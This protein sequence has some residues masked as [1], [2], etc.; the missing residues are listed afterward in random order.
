MAPPSQRKRA[1][2]GL[3]LAERQRH[4]QQ[5]L[6]ATNYPND[7]RAYTNSALQGGRGDLIKVDKY[8]R[9]V[10]RLDDSMT[11]EQKKS[12]GQDKDIYAVAKWNTKKGKWE[13]ETYR[14]PDRPQTEAFMISEGTWNTRTDA[15]MSM[16]P[17]SEGRNAKPN[18]VLRPGKADFQPALNINSVRGGRDYRLSIDDNREGYGKTAKFAPMTFNGIG[19]NAPLDF[20]GMPINPNNPINGIGGQGKYYTDIAGEHTVPNDETYNNNAMADA[21]V[22]GAKPYTAAEKAKT[23]FVGVFRTATDPIGSVIDLYNGN[24]LEHNVEYTG[25]E[26]GIGAALTVGCIVGMEIVQ[27]GRG[28]ARAIQ[29]GTTA[30]EVELG[31]GVVADATESAAATSSRPLAGFSAEAGA[32]R[33]AGAGAGAGATSAEGN[34]FLEPVNPSGIAG[35]DLELMKFGKT[36]N[37]L[38][39][40]DK[41]ATVM[42]S[43]ENNSFFDA[44]RT[45]SPRDLELEGMP[46]LHDKAT[47]VQVWKRMGGTF[48]EEE[49]AILSANDAR[50]DDIIANKPHEAQ[51]YQDP[52]IP[53]TDEQIAK[54]Q[55]MP[56]SQ[57]TEL[58]DDY[59]FLVDSTM[60]RP[61]S[62]F[63]SFDNLL[64]RAVVTEAEEITVESGAANIA[65]DAAESGIPENVG[66]DTFYETTTD[67]YIDDI[68]EEFFDAV[69]DTIPT[70]SVAEPFD[71]EAWMEKFKEIM[72]RK[73]GGE[74][75]TFGEYI[76]AT[77]QPT[78]TGAGDFWDTAVIEGEQTLGEETV[79]ADTS[80]WA[81]WDAL[82]KTKEAWR[83]F[84]RAFMETID[85][86]RV[87]P[88]QYQRI[89]LFVARVSGVCFTRLN[90]G[91]KAVFVS[92]N[93][94]LA[95]GVGWELYRKQFEDYEM[96]LQN[97]TI[98]KAGIL[99]VE[100]DTDDTDSPDDGGIVGEVYE[101]SLIVEEQSTGVQQDEFGNQF[102]IPRFQSTEQQFV[103]QVF[104]FAET[105]INMS[106][107]IFVY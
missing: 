84:Q 10:I 29:A 17:D 38:T 61:G 22:N 18:L 11:A 47:M 43:S 34:F 9:Y 35:Q 4:V 16:V 105:E 107:Y 73:V 46:R 100:N 96:R 32:G 55:R 2:Q 20:K 28:A 57:R 97:E 54:V 89:R 62:S 67:T 3:Y 91:V 19:V 98:T 71:E 12:F 81:R 79:M 86:T 49:Q 48:T 14:F 5:A 78:M 50:I 77:E 92:L 101:P 85:R 37:T 88:E 83:G 53:L 39:T 66:G 75:E 70:E 21:W 6:A 76:A 51:F 33:G 63:P 72:N 60:E 58:M 69:D 95:A 40:I 87:S 15:V 106:E 59:H 36:H 93:A 80:T 64:S 27:G 42:S 104:V 103:G 56:A 1:Q 31:E 90:Y 52:E 23:F 74:G 82:G 94:G 102:E 26:A 24:Y 13:P 8:G 44:V 41:F 65:V 7:R 30:G 45:I 68:E 99:Q 25:K